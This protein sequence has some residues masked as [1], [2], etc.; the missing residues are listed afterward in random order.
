M[1]SDDIY[2]FKII[3]VGE[4]GDIDWKAVY[5]DSCD[6][7]SLKDLPDGTFY[8][9]TDRLIDFSEVHVGDYLVGTPLPVE[10]LKKEIEFSKKT[11]NNADY[12]SL[13]AVLQRIEEG[14]SYTMFI[15]RGRFLCLTKE[16]FPFKVAGEV[17][18]GKVIDKTGA[19]IEDNDNY[20]GLE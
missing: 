18:N 8:I 20:I 5:S 6:I 12:L 3:F 19:K 14:F 16:D 4:G 17:E 9:V 1:Q 15:K 10:V 13:K 11:G 2:R 7:Y